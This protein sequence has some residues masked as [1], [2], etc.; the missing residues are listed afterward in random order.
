MLFS[1][2]AAIDFT[3]SGVSLWLALY[4]LGR[5]FPSRI[6]LRAVVALLALAVFFFSAYINLYVHIPAAG[7]LM[8]ALLTIGLAIWCDLT[9]I[10]FQ[11]RAMGKIRWLVGASYAFAFITVVLLLW[12]RN[13]F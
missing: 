2:T 3:G 1:L 13:N 9:D 10:I 6:T 8:A 5:G 12:S 11:P 4:L 7:P